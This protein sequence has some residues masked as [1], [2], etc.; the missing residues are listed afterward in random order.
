M[1][2][3]DI[4]SLTLADGLPVKVGDKDVKYKQVRLREIGVAD[5]RIATRLAERV[6]YIDGRPTLLVSG[7]DHKYA[8]T[9]RHIAKIS[10]AGGEMLLDE[11]DLDVLGKLSLHDIGLIEERVFLVNLASKVRYGLITQEDFDKLVSG[12]G[13]TAKAPQP[14]GQ[15]QG[16]G[17]DAPG[18]E[19]GPVMLTDFSGMDPAVAV[20][21][22]AG[23]PGTAS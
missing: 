12:K 20:G 19:S 10:G 22:D 17:G 2:T 11:I 6:V 1:T 9:M 4:F 23:V 13:N 7:T 14:Q 16:M 8:L 5:D 21:R 3:Q 15:A 18:G